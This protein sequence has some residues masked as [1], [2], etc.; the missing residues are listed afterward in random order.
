MEQ[1]MSLD[2]M[3]FNGLGFNSLKRYFSVFCALSLFIFLSACALRD[4]G[5][6]AFIANPPSDKAVK[7]AL[8]LPFGSAQKNWKSLAR[9]ISDAAQMALFDSGKTR[10]VLIPK[11]TRGTP[12]GAQRAMEE[13]IAQGAHIVLGPL[14][15][16][17]V[18]AVA[19]LA[20]QYN[21][22]VIAFS[23]DERVVSDN[24]YLLGFSPSQQVR[25]VVQ[26]AKEL[27]VRRM[28]AFL[29]RT[30]YGRLVRTAFVEA[31][32]EFGLEIHAIETY[33]PSVAGAMEPARRLADYNWRRKVREQEMRR[34]EREIS[35]AR[36]QMRSRG[37]QARRGRFV[38]GR[39]QRGQDDSVPPEVRLKKAEADI[40]R[41]KKID[42]LGEVPYRAI[43][44]AEGGALLRGLVQLL[45]NFDITS[46][47]VFFLGTGLWDD[48][49]LGREQPLN[50]ARFAAPPVD[51]AEILIARMQREFRRPIPRLVTLGYDGVGLARTL[52]EQSDP[53]FE[54]A[55]ITQAGGFVG[56]DGIYRFP[57][58]RR[59]T[60][61]GE[62][63]IKGAVAE[64][65]LAVL[66]I[67]RRGREIVSEAPEEFEITR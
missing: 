15:S 29:P 41:L 43:L 17:S 2:I 32:D 53:P 58:T 63:I 12:A 40:D 10:L 48:P 5:E 54:W 31:A 42:A 37:P 64:R 46:R 25:R 47:Q 20:A 28:A 18:R 65:G 33:P 44:F 35:R 16:K 51:N 22:P 4:G 66:E 52:A 56:I 13:A 34:L 57:K 3:R 26:H 55:Q 49:K 50:D 61:D 30:A 45:P 6:A 8:L 9:S 7:V 1:K 38:R 60:L 67:K 39:S 59:S 11:D 23:S 24:V 27:D 62:T 19:P 14:L 21:V 36:T